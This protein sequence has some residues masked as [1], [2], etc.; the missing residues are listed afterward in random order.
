MSFGNIDQ[1]TIEG[2]RRYEELLQAD[3]RNESKIKAIILCHPHNPLGRCYP[4]EALIGFMRLCEKFKVHLIVDEVYALSVYEVPDPKAIEFMSVLSLDTEKY[5]SSKYLHLLYGMSKDIAAGG[6]RLGCFYTKN[7]DLMRAMKNMTQFHWSGVA[8][9]KVAI[10]ML[11]DEEW[12]DGFL[13]SSRA[14]LEHNNVKVRKMLDDLGIKYYLGSNAGFFIWVDLRDFLK[15]GGDK[16]DAEA[17]LLERIKENRAYMTA[18]GAMAA[19]EPG[20]FRLI[21]SLD[22]RVI[23]E[24]LRRLIFID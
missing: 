12:M 16:W 18:G 5:I 2:V 14:R 21:F 22:E 7:A 13:R 6:I 20:W 4:R 10:A 19:E 1:F 3:R 15:E 8:D 23:E 17:E 11:E 24:G 9:E